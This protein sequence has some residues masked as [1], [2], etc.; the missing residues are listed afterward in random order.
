MTMKKQ[1]RESK[2]PEQVRA[3]DLVLERPGGNEE[4]EASQPA[5]Q[6]GAH[7]DILI[8]PC[9]PII[10]PEANVKNLNRLDLIIIFTAVLRVVLEGGFLLFFYF[11]FLFYEYFYYFICLSFNYN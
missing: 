9:G 5:G 3:C 6:R 8:S 10:D 1:K 7:Q 4:L 2:R 11:F